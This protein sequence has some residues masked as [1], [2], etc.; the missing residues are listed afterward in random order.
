[1]YSF[2]SPAPRFFF[3]PISKPLLCLTR[4]IQKYI[5]PKTKLYDLRETEKSK[6]SYRV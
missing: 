4:F 6:Y 1:M 3:K 2:L 5:Q